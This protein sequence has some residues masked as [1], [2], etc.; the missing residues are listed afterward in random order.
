MAHVKTDFWSKMDNFM[1][2]IVQKSDGTS[3]KIWFMM[4][5]SVVAIITLD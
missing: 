4:S 2:K 1:E 3:V 5:Y